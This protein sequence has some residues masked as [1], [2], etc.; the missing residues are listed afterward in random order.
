MDACR[1]IITPELLA[2]SVDYKS[3][4]MLVE[5]RLKVGKTT[6][7]DHSE[8][9]INFSQLNL[10]RMK[11]WD[12]IIQLSEDL[13]LAIGQIDSKQEWIVLTEGWCGDAAQNLPLI[14][15]IA[16]SN[17]NIT[18]RLLLRDENLDLMDC[19][20]TNGGRSIPKLIVLDAETKQELGTWGP[21]PAPVQEMLYEMKAKGDFSYEYFSLLSHTWY[22]KDK[23]KTA[24]GE[25]LSIIKNL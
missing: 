17:D 4:R 15:K 1:E 13:K 23:S 7:E 20:L 9:L 6:G 16:E 11:K 19:H 18:L 5:E 21:R 22:A 10:Q 25:F 14:N 3:Y 2:K 24:Q 8:S 12:K